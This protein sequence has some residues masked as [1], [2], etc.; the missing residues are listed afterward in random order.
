MEVAEDNR[1]RQE[2]NVAWVLPEQSN[3]L[4]DLGE[5]EHENELSPERTLSG[6]HVPIGGGPPAG[7]EQKGV[8]QE[9]KG[10]E[11]RQVQRVRAPRLLAK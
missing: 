8:D 6:F 7:R 9:G 3:K 4:D 11:S 10:R 5:A 1:H 2:H